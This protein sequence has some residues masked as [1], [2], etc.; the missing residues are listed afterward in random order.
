MERHGKIG[1][2]AL[3]LAGIS[4]ACG[5]A[6]PTGAE[7]GCDTGA[8]AIGVTDGMASILCGCAEAAGTWVANGGALTCTVPAGT[9]VMFHYINPLNRHQIVSTAGSV[10]SFAPSPVYLPD[11]PMAIRSHAV[12]LEASGNY[13]FTDTFDTS[14]SAT[15]SVP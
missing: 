5:T 9:T 11:S 4:A 3:A 6:E 10:L 1:I 14:L 8:A 13:D 7:P 2:L 15:L 12:R